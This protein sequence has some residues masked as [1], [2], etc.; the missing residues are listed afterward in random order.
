MLTIESYFG[1]KLRHFGICNQRHF[2][3]VL[4]VAF[5]KPKMLDS[6]TK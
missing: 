3:N 5:N 2:L 1:E 6:V 4:M